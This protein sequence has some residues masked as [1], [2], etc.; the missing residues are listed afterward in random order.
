MDSSQRTGTA[1]AGT[2]RRSGG[3]ALLVAVLALASTACGA[4][5]DR[6]TERVIERAIES[7]TGGSVNIDRSGDGSFS[8]ETDEGTFAFGAGEV[9][10][11]IANEF[12]LPRD[13]D[14]LS[15]SEITTDGEATALVVLY[16]ESAPGSV[17]EDLQR[18][19]EAKGW[20]VGTTYT[21]GGTAGFEATRGGDRLT[22]F[23]QSDGSTT[24]L[25]IGISRPA[26]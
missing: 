5:A 17:L 8:V 2:T 21:A 20:T 4:I 15:A 26:G 25:T 22:V 6:A 12:D 19:A 11:V 1:A 18:Q 23:G 14:V 24:N 7:E 16:R 9:P 13:L 3:A 10:A